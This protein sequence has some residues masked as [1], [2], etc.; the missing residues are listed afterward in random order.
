[1]TRAQQHS[2]IGIL[3]IFLEMSSDFVD[4][5]MMMLEIKTRMDAISSLNINFLAIF[6]SL[7]YNL[8]VKCEFLC[9]DSASSECT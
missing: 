1:M 4:F 8:A 6:P 2:N 3:N 7:R 9:S 5:K